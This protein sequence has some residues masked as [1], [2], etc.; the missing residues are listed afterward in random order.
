MN[1][2]EPDRDG[3]PRPAALL[4]P[5]QCHAAKSAGIPL[6]AIFEIAGGA[7]GDQPSDRALI[8]ARACLS[9]W[10]RHA[11][12][13]DLELPPSEKEFVAVEARRRRVFGEIAAVLAEVESLQRRTSTH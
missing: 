11:H 8:I 12:F 9:G 1:A 5:Y 10:L 4:L 6:S 3:S 13:A 2:S 7:E